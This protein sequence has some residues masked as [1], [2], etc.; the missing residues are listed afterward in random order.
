MVFL[1]NIFLPE[2]IILLFLFSFVYM[3]KKMSYIN[4]FKKQILSLWRFFPLLLIYTDYH[5]NI[6]YFFNNL[7]IPCTLCPSLSSL[8]VQFS[9][10]FFSNFLTYYSLEVSF[11]NL[12]V[13]NA[14]CDFS[15]I[16][17]I[18]WLSILC[19]IGDNF[20]IYKLL[21]H[22]LLAF[23]LAFAFHWL[24]LHWL[25]WPIFV[26]PLKQKELSSVFSQRADFFSLL[27][28]VLVGLFSSTRLNPGVKI[29]FENLWTLI[30]IH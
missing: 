8:T 2:L 1:S 6:F 3:N 5:L 26:F 24:L 18:V 12:N 4:I 22:W 23:D 11:G 30:V 29:Q 13:E 17:L 20:P 7:E 14:F 27:F 9:R 21:L 15:H 19:Y 28:L 10:T 16:C 25:H